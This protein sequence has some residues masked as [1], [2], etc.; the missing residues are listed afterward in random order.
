LKASQVDLN[1]LWELNALLQEK[2][3]TRAAK[4]ADLSEPAMSRAFRRLRLTFGDELLVRVGREYHLTSFAEQLVTPVSEILRLVTQTI[5]DR[6]FFDPEIDERDFAVAASDYGAFLVLRPL[7]SIMIEQAPRTTLRIQQFR[8]ETF[9]DLEAQR[10]DLVLAPHP[11]DR[12]LSHEA[13]FD[14]EWFCAVWTGHPSIGNTISE[15]EYFT[16]PHL[17][18]SFGPEYSGVSNSAITDGESS[19]LNTV[20]MASHFALPFFLKNSRL[21][22][23]VPGR[24]GRQIAS[25]AEIRLLKPPFEL[26]PIHLEMVWH[27]RND[28]DPAHCWLRNRLQ[29]ICAGLVAG[30][31][32]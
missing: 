31:G 29:E 24:T 10:I 25:S 7:T 4:R 6:P 5:E 13:L 15:Q 32:A 28:K 23:M 26:P 30:E 8:S 11:G 27:P 2:H 3:V 22:A 9:D 1:L 18:Y 20:T 16:Q 19:L 21:V 17:K 14:D 12:Q